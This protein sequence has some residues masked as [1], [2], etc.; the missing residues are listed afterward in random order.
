M[1]TYFLLGLKDSS[2]SYLTT[3]SCAKLKPSWF[4]SLKPC[5]LVL[6]ALKTA[7]LFIS[8]RPCWCYHQQANIYSS[9]LGNN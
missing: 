7:G 2:V 5:I 8:Q 1:I 6:Y 9:L 3:G 4:L